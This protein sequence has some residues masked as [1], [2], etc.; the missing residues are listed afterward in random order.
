M[1]KDQRLKTLPLK[2]LS[3]RENWYGDNRLRASCE[4]EF[5]ATLD[6]IIKEYKVMIAG[7]SAVAK[8]EDTD[9][10]KVSCVAGTFE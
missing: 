7:S 5:L 9:D 1:I 8:V 6:A 4:S 3:K 2:T 10:R